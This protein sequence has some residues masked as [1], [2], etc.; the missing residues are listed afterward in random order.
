MSD[1][2]KTWLYALG[3][4]VVIGVV[5]YLAFNLLIYLIPV[6]VVIYII[7]KIKNYIE[8]KKRTNST[9]NNTTQYKSSYDSK[10]ED[11]DSSNGEVIDVDY[12]DVNK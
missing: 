4:L 11:V 9:I 6:L 10:I 5:A 1:R 2:I 7:F 8:G 12:E 3:S